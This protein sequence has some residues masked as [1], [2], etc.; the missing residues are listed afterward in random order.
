MDG[1]SRLRATAS[2][3][4]VESR[5]VRT[6]DLR[7]DTVTRPSPGMRDAMARAEVGDDVYGE[8]PTV[9]RLQE[10]AARLLGKAAGLFVPSGTMGNQVCL[11]ALASRGESVLAAEGAHMLLY[12][13]GAAAALAGVQIHALGRN[14]H[15]DGDDLAAAY[16]PEEAHLSPTRLVCLENTHNHA[17]GLVLSME[18]QQDIVKAARERE[19][20]LHL[21]GA[22]LFHA[23]TATGISAA[24]WAEPF[25]TVTFCLSK[26]LGAPVGSVVCGAEDVIRRAHRAR[27]QLG[28]GMRQVGVLAAAGLYA[29]EH[30]RDRL[31]EDHA[32][33]R[34]LATGLEEL[35]FPVERPPE[36]NMV[37]FGVED[38]ESFARECQ[39]RELLINPMGQRRFRAVTHLDIDA[40]GI[41][42]ALERI[43]EVTKR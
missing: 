30:N 39:A 14:G 26:G 28:G 23:V 29:L 37:M 21:D 4:V 27:K 6:L 35:G 32:N 24:R 3:R 5:P 19:L 15:F 36:T 34:R 10:E 2:D 17:G 1:L 7:S 41:E 20:S 42:E 38:A 22:R 18:V 8:D 12:E 31:A 13:S 9:N 11:H 43:R 33:A 40:D 16:T 25:D